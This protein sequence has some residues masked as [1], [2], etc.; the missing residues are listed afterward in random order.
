MQVPKIN[1]TENA[2]KIRDGFVSIAILE[3]F[4]RCLSGGKQK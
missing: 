1:I 4:V 3:L 2:I